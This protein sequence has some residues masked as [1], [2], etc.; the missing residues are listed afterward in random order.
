MDTHNNAVAAMMASDPR[1]AG[2][3]TAE[4]ARLAIRSGCLDI[5]KK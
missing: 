2:M 3:S 5:I 4:V 1:Y